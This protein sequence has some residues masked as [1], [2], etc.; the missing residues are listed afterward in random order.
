MNNK[1][2]HLKSLSEIRTLMRESSK[3]ISLSG[4]SGVSAGI[5][6]LIGAFFAYNYMNNLHENT[7]YNERISTHYLSDFVKFFLIDAGFVLIVAAGLAIFFTTRKAKQEGLAIWDDTA[8]RLVVN[9]LLPL[10]AGG[11][12]C[13]IMLYHGITIMIAPATLIFYGLALINAS[14]YTLGEVRWL[15]ITEIA[16]GLLAAMFPR[17]GLL[18]WALGFGVMHIV[19][20]SYMYFKYER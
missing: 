10:A 13:L 19:Y 14:K 18:F 2:Q 20:G 15:G 1:E 3:F 9:L 17:N 5:T 8:K 4:L 11:I 12:F 7:A 16:L 6:A